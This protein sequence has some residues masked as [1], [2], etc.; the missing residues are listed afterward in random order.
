MNMNM[1]TDEFHDVIM[2]YIINLARVSRGTLDDPDSE[3]FTPEFDDFLRHVN[4][5][6]L[7]KL[8]TSYIREDVKTRMYY[9]RLKNVMPTAENVRIIT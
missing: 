5:R 6:P 4:S 3:V 8:R 1:T 9:K 7:G 2:L